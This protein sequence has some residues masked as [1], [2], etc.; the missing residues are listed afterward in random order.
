MKNPNEIIN[1]SVKSTL[2]GKFYEK[3]IAGWIRE[4]TEFTP[5]N[6]KSRIF[7]RAY[8]TGKVKWGIYL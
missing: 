3:I 6:G 1:D 8:K 2:F 5:L 7:W 4:A